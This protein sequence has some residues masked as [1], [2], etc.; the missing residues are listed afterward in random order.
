MKNLEDEKFTKLK[1]KFDIKGDG[2]IAYK[3]LIRYFVLG[4]KPTRIA[5]GQRRLLRKPEKDEVRKQYIKLFF[6]NKVTLQFRESI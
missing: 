1:E 2:T 6:L 5:H 3:D 4:L